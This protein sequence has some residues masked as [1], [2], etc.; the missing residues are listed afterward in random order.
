MFMTTIATQMIQT[1]MT[2]R[3]ISWM[4][5]QLSLVAVCYFA[6]PKVQQTATVVVRTLPTQIRS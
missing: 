6:T 2:L 4:G 5:T 3:I 1:R